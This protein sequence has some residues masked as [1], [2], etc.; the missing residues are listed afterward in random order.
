M[1]QRSRLVVP[2]DKVA[3]DRGGVDGGM[4][5]STPSTRLA[6]P[7]VAGDQIDRRVVATGI[8]DRHRGVLQADGA[9]APIASG[10]PSILA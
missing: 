1:L 10:L 4:R 5:H 3:H 9:V 2:F 7:D 6:R 8:V